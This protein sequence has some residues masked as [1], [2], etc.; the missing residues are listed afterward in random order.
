MVLVCC[1]LQKKVEFKVWR[2]NY[3]TLFPTR[4]A[5][6]QVSRFGKCLSRLNGWKFELKQKI[7]LSSGRKWRSTQS[8]LKEIVNFFPNTSRPET[9]RTQLSRLIPHMK[10]TLRKEQTLKIGFKKNFDIKYQ[11]MV[12]YP[13]SQSKRRKTCWALLEK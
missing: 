8:S 5:V 10:K 1:P 11:R 3:L 7:F 9:R 6:S 4:E 13:I 2:W 12:F